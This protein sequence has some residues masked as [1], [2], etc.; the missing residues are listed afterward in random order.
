VAAARREQAAGSELL[1]QRRRSGKLWWRGSG[2]GASLRRGKARGVLN[3]GGGREEK[4]LHGEQMAGDEVVL[5]RR[6]C[7]CNRVVWPGLG[8]PQE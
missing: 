3:L 5:W 8:A 2:M 6:H 7:G 4:R 1:R